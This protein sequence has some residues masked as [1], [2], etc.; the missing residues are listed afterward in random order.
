MDTSR[1]KGRIWGSLI[2]AL[3]LLTAPALA[4]AAQLQTRYSLVHGCYALTAANGKAVAGG[5]H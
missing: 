5:E 4:Q 2:V 3:A 1:A